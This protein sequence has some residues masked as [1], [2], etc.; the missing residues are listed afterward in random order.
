MN[1]RQFLAMPVAAAA[2]GVFAGRAAVGEPGAINV[3][4]QELDKVVGA[5]PEKPF[6]VPA[7][8]RRLLVFSLTKGFPHSSVDLGARTFELLGA[9]TGA[10]TTV[11]TKDVAM[12]KPESLKGFDAVVM[13]NTTGRNLLDDPALRQSLLDFVKGG[14]GLVGLHG[15][16]DAFYEKWPE[17][18]E[19]MGGYFAGHPFRKISVKIDDPASPLTAMFDGQGFAF[20]DEIY[21]FHGPY[22]R[23]KLRILL[24]IDWENSGLSGGNRKDNDYALSWIR[25]YGEGRTFYCAFGHD[26]NVFW[27][28]TILKHLLAGTQFALGDLKA[29]ATP[30]AKASPA[31]APARGPVLAPQPEKKPKPAAKPADKK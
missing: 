7:R 19:M 9:K 24:S 10:W 23:E 30:S 26:H 25:T 2:L 14:K 31:P 11:I 18:G 29:D 28:P 4:P 17:Y 22:S 5:L 13:N 12:F 8:P 15:A 27:N 16:T 3:T 1:R 6:A 21:T 20:S